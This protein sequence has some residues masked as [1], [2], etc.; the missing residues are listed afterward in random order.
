MKSYSVY[1]LVFICNTGYEVFNI[2]LTTWCALD[3]QTFGV[4]PT[5]SIYGI[6]FEASDV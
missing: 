3:Q 2:L 5:V 6:F 1:V 4:L